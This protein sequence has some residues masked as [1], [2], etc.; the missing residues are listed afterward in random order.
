[1]DGYFD[2]SIDKN[3][4][5]EIKDSTLTRVD[6]DYIYEATKQADALFNI[7]TSK[8]K[9]YANAVSGLYS[10]IKNSP[11]I[12]ENIVNNGLNTVE[13]INKSIAQLDSNDPK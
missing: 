4:T 1:L 2:S 12:E 13:G 3:T 5:G 9:D 7:S 6:W 10:V 8:F 11:E